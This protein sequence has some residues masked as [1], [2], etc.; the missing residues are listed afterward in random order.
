M[1]TARRGFRQQCSLKET[2]CSRP[3][4]STNIVTVKVHGSISADE[5]E[6]AQKVVADVV[7]EHGR[8]R[9]LLDY[10]GVDHG[11]VEPKAVWEDLKGAH[12]LGDTDRIGVVSDSPALDTFVEAMGAVSH[13]EVRTFGAD[14][15]D[16]AIAW[17]SA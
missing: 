15:R 8:A 9:I 13:L 17:L 5:D 16:A 2:T 11:R 10:D 6:A 3:A 4:S 1:W 7:S 12:L 14:Q